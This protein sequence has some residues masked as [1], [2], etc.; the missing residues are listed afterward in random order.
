MIRKLHTTS[1]DDHALLKEFLAD[2]ETGGK[3]V[4]WFPHF[5]LDPDRDATHLLRNCPAIL[6]D[7]THQVLVLF[8]T[9]PL[10][11]AWAAHIMAKPSGR[12]GLAMPFFDLALGWAFLQ[13]HRHMIFGTAWHEDRAVQA[14]AHL[15]G[16]NTLVNTRQG[17]CIDRLSYE[18]W[19]LQSEYL[20]DLG[21]EKLGFYDQFQPYEIALTGLAR[22]CDLW[23]VSD[24]GY[25]ALIHDAFGAVSAQRGA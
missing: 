12:R 2:P 24:R 17:W 14:F 5:V 25:G 7:P 21:K 19:A 11:Y 10:P 15:V 8:Q 22:L 9:T 23:K 1:L 3:V 6:V 18:E 13:A 16:M 20:M 4:R